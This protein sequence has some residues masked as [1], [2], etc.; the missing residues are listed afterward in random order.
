MNISAYPLLISLLERVFKYSVSTITE[1][2]SEKSP[3]W[4]F[5]EFKLMPVLLP[6]DA[7]TIESRVVGIFTKSIPLLYVLAINPPIS[8]ITPPPKFI[9][10]LF[11][12]AFLFV[13]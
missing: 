11:L 2:G 6:I 7:S 9:R 5:I 8:V 12:S 1:T 3:I 10:R 4:F 13:K